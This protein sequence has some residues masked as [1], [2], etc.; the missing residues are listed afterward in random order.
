MLCLLKSFTIP[1][2]H[3]AKEIIL[4]RSWP[5]VI[6]VYSVQPALHMMLLSIGLEMIYFII[7]AV[8]RMLLQPRVPCLTLI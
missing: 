5:R 8:D 6:L 4:D 2:A 3:M 1:L 7:I